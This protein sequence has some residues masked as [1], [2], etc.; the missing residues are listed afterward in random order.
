MLYVHWEADYYGGSGGAEPQGNHK[1]MQFVRA[2]I[3]LDK[4]IYNQHVA[5]QGG[6]RHQEADYYWGVGAREKR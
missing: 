2:R 3:G 1:Q 5:Y 4:P 6:R